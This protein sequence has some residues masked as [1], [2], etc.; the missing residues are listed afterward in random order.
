MRIG[1]Q[2]LDRFLSDLA[3]PRPTPG[4]GAAAAVTGATAAALVEMVVNLTR[5]KEYKNI[6][7]RA[8]ELRKRLL[9]LADEDCAAFAA[10]IKAYES[11][12]RFKIRKALGEAIAVPQKTK[13]LAY[14]VKRLAQRMI[15]VGNQNAYSDAKSAEYLAQAAIKAAEENIKINQKLLAARP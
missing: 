14:E 11:K 7:N 13:K 2:K 1:N 10:V 4:G 15:E 5:E 9:E 3:S 6:G 12:S 8:G